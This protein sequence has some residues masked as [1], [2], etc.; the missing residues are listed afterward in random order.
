MNAWKM[1]TTCCA[2]ALALLA[3]CAEA[4][5]PGTD[6]GAGGDPITIITQP[7]TTSAGSG[8][9][10]TG[11]TGG[12]GESSSSSGVV[13]VDL[14]ELCKGTWGVPTTTQCCL[15]AGWWPDTCGSA[16]CGEVITCSGEID[17]QTP[18]C[19]CPQGQ[20]FDREAGCVDAG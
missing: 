12:A 1:G 17:P 14:T 6:Q 9:S 15:D 11:S 7:S 18:Y 13:Q 4:T 20:C 2:L 5:G 16:H 19:Q 3:G 10:G 8:G